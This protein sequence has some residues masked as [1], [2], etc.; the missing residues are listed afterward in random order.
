MRTHRK[1]AILACAMA[2]ASPAGAEP[3]AADCAALS[4]PLRSIEGYAFAAP[5]AADA[6]GWCVFDGATLRTKAGDAPNASAERLRLKGSVEDG[7]LVGI[8]AEVVGLRIIPKA[9][10]RE[11]D[12]RLRSLLR[13]QTLDASF[14]ASVNA[15]EVQL[16]PFRLRLGSGM[17]LRLEL[18][19]K[20]GGLDGASLLAGSL[21]AVT[22][23]WENDGRTLRPLMEIAG[24]R[25]V[26]G[27]QG[28]VAVDATRTALRI[29]SENLPEAF[30][31]EEARAELETVIDALPHGRGRL[32]L[33]FTSEAGMNAAR[34]GVLA[35][36]GD[37]ASP[38][39]LARFLAGA[40]LEL[41]WDPGLQP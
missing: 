18:D 31:A 34:L 36:S 29:H 40:R 32:L 25:L 39:A 5:A 17:A 35:L 13:L 22:L 7:A 30:F 6:D 9:G 37:P 20:A 16:R 15:G 14:S 21:T 33:T 10:D 2:L 24:E 11:M 4:A 1:L 19:G 3:V 41:N 8:T 26:D 12:D 23:D 27:A 38:E 28:S